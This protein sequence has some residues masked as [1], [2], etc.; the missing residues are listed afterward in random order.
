MKTLPLRTLTA[1]IA[2]IMAAT[3]TTR[4][5]ISMLSLFPCPEILP[6]RMCLPTAIRPRTQ[7]LA[8][9]VFATSNTIPNRV[10]TARGANGLDKAANPARPLLGALVNTI[11]KLAPTCLAA[12]G[13]EAAVNPTIQAIPRAVPALVAT[14]LSL[15]DTFRAANGAAS[16]AN[17]HP[18]TLR[19]QHNIAPLLALTLLAVIGQAAIANP[20]LEATRLVALAPNSTTLSRVS[21]SPVATGL[22]APASIPLRIRRTLLQPKLRLWRCLLDNF[23]I[24][25]KLFALLKKSLFGMLF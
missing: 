5:L 23:V 12:S 17:L 10:P 1:T 14:T 6:L 21:T 25:P 19:A 15:A 2:T 13:P 4:T 20:T 9:Q 24:V 7:T 3:T 8:S 22:A 16:P 18:A 11:L